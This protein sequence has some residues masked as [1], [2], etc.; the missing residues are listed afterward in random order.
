MD[1]R[2]FIRVSALSAAGLWLPVKDGKTAPSEEGASAEPR[3]DVKPSSWLTPNDKFYVQ[4]I[5]AGE[6]PDVD[7]AKWK[8][9]VNGLVKK[10]KLLKYSDILEA[11]SV[12]TERTLSCIGD[13]VG[14]EQI[15]NAVWKGV[16]VST[17]LEAPQVR[18]QA[19]RVV[20]KCADGYHTGV[21]IE[22]A[23]HE[24]AVL[25]YEM[26]GEPLPQAHGFPL[27]FLNP[28]KYG[29]K[30]PK[31]IIN[32]ELV[33]KEYL[34]Y[35]EGRGWDDTAAVRMATRINIPEAGDAL[36]SGTYR[37]SGSAYDGGNHGGIAH[38]EVS[39]DGGDTWDNA[40]I[41]GSG[42]VRSWYLW[43]YEW[44]V[45]GGERTAKILA[46]S[47]GADREVQTSKPED[48][49]PRGASGYHTL[50]VDISA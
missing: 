8:L 45:P 12:M 29:Q 14:G 13:P 1:R 47:I 16:R 17:L 23:L 46:R 15:G 21:P 36:P 2:T 33:A 40:S 28:G 7:I 31:W 50:E 6:R 11:P 24:D 30:C 34:G 4:D 26:N 43:E 49:H 10:P 5:T 19:S 18:E 39:T 37:I 25:A 38:V 27:R 35:W 42:S 3:D 48:G 44:T 32:M 9:I 22:D 41:W 20:F